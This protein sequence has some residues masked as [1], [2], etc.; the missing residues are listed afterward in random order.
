MIG[1]FF[2]FGRQPRIAVEPDPTVQL[3]QSE[4]R[5]TCCGE[6]HH[7]LMD[8][9]AHSPDPWLDERTYE[10]NS[11]LRLDGNFLSEDFC[12]LDGEHFFVRSVLEIPV[13]GLEAPWGF[14]CWTTLSRTNFDKYIAGFDD[15]EYEDSGPWFGWLSNR[16]KIYFEDAQPIKVDVFPQRN[17]QRPRLMVQDAEHPLGAAQRKGISAEATLQLLS[18]YGHGPT[19]Q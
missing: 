1:R 11:A 6:W 14:G 18:A 17:R 19:V 12:V 4:W 15:G 7:G 8:I 2:G 13:R 16:L 3:L 5:C 10:P 9:A